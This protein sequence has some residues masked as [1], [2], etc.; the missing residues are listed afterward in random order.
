[1][2]RRTK[3]ALLIL[4]ASVALMG[5]YALHLKRR[6]EQLPVTAVDTRPVAPPVSGTAEQV[7]LF[8][9]NDADGML[10]KQSVKI[11][12]P[13]DPTERAR[14]VVRALISAYLEKNSNHPLAT[15][16][17][18]E[19]VF[20]VKPNIAVVDTNA[21]FADG[22]RSGILVEQL[23]VASVAQTL[24]ANVPNIGRVKIL[25][26]GKERETLAGHADLTSFYDLSAES[27]P[28]AP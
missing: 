2:T 19:A 18:V 25:V 23:T 15:G 14:Q 20:L 1:V 13:R 21:E 3:I 7:T 16:A 11:A 8:V 26:Q 17:D 9:A 12:L 27:W 24:A 28:I 22:H 4:V 5:Y 10:H 6:A